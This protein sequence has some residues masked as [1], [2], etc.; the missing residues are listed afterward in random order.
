MAAISQGNWESNESPIPLLSGDDLFVRTSINSSI[1]RGDLCFFSWESDV[2]ED[3]VT[4]SWWSS[5]VS[6][7]ESVM[8]GN[9]GS[10]WG[11]F[12]CHVRE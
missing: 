10:S 6:G 5:D 12:A 11:I 1:G 9:E 8:S 7:V 4:A 2:S 3:D